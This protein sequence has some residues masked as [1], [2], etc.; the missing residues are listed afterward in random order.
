M[1]SEAWGKGGHICKWCNETAPQL[2]IFFSSDGKELGGATAEVMLEARWTFWGLL[3]GG[4]FLVF[5]LKQGEAAMV[6]YRG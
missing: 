5:F 3:P 6:G 4:L 2:L 1:G